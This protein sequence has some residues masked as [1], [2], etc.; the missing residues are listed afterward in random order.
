MSKNGT[1]FGKAH[2][3]YR[4]VLKIYVLDRRGKMLIQ[5]QSMTEA[6]KMR[7]K[8]RQRGIPSAVVQT[9]PA[10]RRGGCGYSREVS[11]SALSKVEEIAEGL[12]VHILGVLGRDGG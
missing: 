7:K 11:E 2:I 9:P 12:G 3:L 1:F 10:A 4:G 6:V 5:V 8:L